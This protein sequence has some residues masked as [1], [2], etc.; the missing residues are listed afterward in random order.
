[1]VKQAQKLAPGKEVR[2]H[3]WRGGMRSGA[4]L[5]LLELAGFKVH[6]LDKGYKDYRREVLA[7]FDTPRNWRV[8]GG[9]TGSGK[10]TCCTRWRPRPT[11]SP[12]STSRA[13]QPQRLGVRGHWAT[14][15]AHP[16]QFENNLAAALAE[17]PLDAP[18]GWRTKA[19][20]LAGSPFHLRCLRKCARPRA[21]Y[22]R[23]PGR[24]AWPNWPPSTGPRPR[25]TWPPLSS[26]CTSASAGW[27]PASLAAVEAAISRAW[28]SWCS[29]YYDKTYTYGLASARR[30]QPHV[31]PRGHLRPDG[32][33]LHPAPGFD[34]AG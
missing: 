1:M 14:A 9:L 8:L 19:G 3:C 2:L 21:G 23:C 16:E 30:A 18:F 31:H 33:C 11:P 4:V 27:P 7:S 12:C 6:L 29:I 13:G 32:E 15:P 17:L 24:P 22:W 26:G 20:K 28:W 5:W 34:N 25:P 10:P